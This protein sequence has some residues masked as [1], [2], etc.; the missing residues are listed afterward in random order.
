MNTTLE[1]TLRFELGSVD[2]STAEDLAAF[3]ADAIGDAYPA[4]AVVTSRVEETPPA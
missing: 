2:L 3:V 4:A 1:I